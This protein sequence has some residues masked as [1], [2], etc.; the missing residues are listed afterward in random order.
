MT[1]KKSNLFRGSLTELHIPVRPALPD[2][3]VAVF[4]AVSDRRLQRGDS[5]ILRDR[6][7][8]AAGQPHKVEW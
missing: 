6:N 8:E 2:R 5:I 7:V 3:D 1:K 4:A